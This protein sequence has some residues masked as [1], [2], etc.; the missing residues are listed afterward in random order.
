[1]SSLWSARESAEPMTDLEIPELRSRDLP[2]S[3][4]H[5]SR[6]R[7]AAWSGFE[8]DMAFN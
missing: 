6:Q 2:R 5:E 1:V 8:I 3:R 4:S 7:R